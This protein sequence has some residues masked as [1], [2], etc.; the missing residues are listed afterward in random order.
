VAD[1]LTRDGVQALS[2]R[3]DWNH[4]ERLA[5]ARRRGEA[6]GTASELEESSYLAEA[7]GL[8]W[9]GSFD[10]FSN[11]LKKFYLSISSSPLP[12]T[13]KGEPVRRGIQLAAEASELK[14]ET[15]DFLIR[16]GQVIKQLGD[17]E[18]SL[19]PGKKAR[20]FFDE[21]APEH[22]RAV[23][24]FFWNETFDDGPIAEDLRELKRLF[25]HEYLGEARNGEFA[26]LAEFWDWLEENPSQEKTAQQWRRYVDEDD[27]VLHSITLSIARP[28]GWLGLVHCSPTI[29]ES[30]FVRLSPEGRSWLINHR[31]EEIPRS[32]NPAAKFTCNGLTMQC[33]L[34]LPFGFQCTIAKYAELTMNGDYSEFR[35]SKS[36]LKE[37][38]LNGNDPN[39]LIGLLANNGGALS[40]ELSGLLSSVL[41][42]INAQTLGSASGFLEF[43]SEGLADK[44]MRDDALSSLVLRRAGKVIILRPDLSLPSVAGQLN[45]A[46]YPVVWGHLKD[47]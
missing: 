37:S 30:Q 11:D 36:R 31:F 46:G 10:G 20:S 26:R 41:G 34:G 4:W 1:R 24:N 47:S 44:L 14:V 40:D 9:E 16:C 15:V 45:E 35:F 38:V 17:D 19:R 12:L 7:S 18:G 21:W 28:L 23:A 22:A 39:E 32:E 25:V 27:E 43:E 2:Q 42:Q 5:K 6:S 33:D 3:I 8:L 13:R 29:D